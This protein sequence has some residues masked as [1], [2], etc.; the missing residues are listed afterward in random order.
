MTLHTV[1]TEIP[2]RLRAMGMRMTAERALLLRILDANPHLDAEE[3]HRLARSERPTIGLATVYRTLNLLSELGAV[4][5][6]ELGEDHRHYEVRRE[7][8]V[9][10]ICLGCGAVLDIASPGGLR[11][12]GAREGFEVRQARLEITGYCANCRKQRPSTAHRAGRAN[13]RSAS[14]A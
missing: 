9:H 11:D 14:D 2:A 5:T 3:I 6:S 4:R 13:A 8:H 1:R 7:D 10:L 12:L